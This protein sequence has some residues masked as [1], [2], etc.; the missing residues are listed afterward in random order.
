MNFEILFLDVPDDYASV[1]RPFN[2]FEVKSHR[3]QAWDF[4]NG[5]TP[6]IYNC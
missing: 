6:D 1:S 5:E 2:A 4:S 3:V